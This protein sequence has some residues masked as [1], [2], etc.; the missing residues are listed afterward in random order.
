MKTILLLSTLLIFGLAGVSYAQLEEGNLMLGTDMGSG[1]TNTT[2]NGLFS[3][4]FGLNDGAGYNIG[5]SPK[6]GYFINDNLVLGA[7]VN[8]GFSK[9]P[10]SEGQSTETFIYGVQG[11]SRFYIRPGDVNLNNLV[12][13][14]RFFLENNA[15]IAG[16]NVSGGNTTNGFTFGFG[17]GY[18]W[19]VNSYIA[20]EANVKYNGLVGAGNT[21]YQNSLGVNLG[22]QI[23]LPRSEARE[24][25]QDFE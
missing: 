5:L 12:R 20:L 17:P 6:A 9:S 22:I 23:F 4:D 19:F 10:R 1:I 15:G 14:G 13:T 18:S 25:L 8:L 2:N 7:I 24:R 3:M 21:D 16:V 11:F